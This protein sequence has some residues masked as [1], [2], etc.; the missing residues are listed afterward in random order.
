MA[1]QFCPDDAIQTE[2]EG[3]KLKVIVSEH[4]KCV[5]C[6]H[7]RYDVVNMQLILSYAAVAWKTLRALANTGTMRDFTMLKWLWLSL[8]AVIWIRE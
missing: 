1:E 6:W 3:V 4:K 7:Q 5:R 2:L 8:L